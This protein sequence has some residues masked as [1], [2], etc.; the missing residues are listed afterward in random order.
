[1]PF[2]AEEG[3]VPVVLE[4]LREGS[5]VMALKAVISSEDRVVAFLLGAY[6]RKPSWP[7]TFQRSGSRPFCSLMTPTPA[8]WL[9]VPESSI[10]L[11]GLQAA[12][13]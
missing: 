3:V 1:M 11:V 12:A 10:A 7:G 2:A 4:Q 6:L 8:M 5:D 9:S 13:V